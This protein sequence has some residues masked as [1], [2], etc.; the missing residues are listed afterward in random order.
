MT[1]LPEARSIA[2]AVRRSVERPNME[3]SKGYFKTKGDDLDDRRLG[4]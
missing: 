2:S 3:T 1:K 4:T